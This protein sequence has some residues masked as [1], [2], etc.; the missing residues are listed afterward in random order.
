MSEKRANE[1]RQIHAPFDRRCFDRRSGVFYYQRRIHLGDTQV[2][3]GT[4]YY[5]QYWDFI[6]EAREEFLRFLLGANL[7]TFMT[8]GIALVTVNCTGYYLQS[9]FA[10]DD[11][12]VNV[13]VI[14]AGNI[15]LNLGFELINQK[16]EVCFRAEMQVAAMS[17]NKPEKWPDF[18]LKP[19]KQ[20][21]KS[22]ASSLK[23][24]V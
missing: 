12:R 13:R 3:G 23:M 19:L 8:S 14:K 20:L 11:I 9:L 10:Y 4:V 22:S 2:M 1:R 24:A 17:G 21:E 7:A 5:A 16:Q 18:L 15:K 6:G